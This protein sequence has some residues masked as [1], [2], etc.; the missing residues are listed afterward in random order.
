MK[1]LCPCGREF[2][3]VPSRLYIQLVCDICFEYLRD[4]WTAGGA[5]CWHRWGRRSA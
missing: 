2:R 3:H 5:P 4:P 1:L